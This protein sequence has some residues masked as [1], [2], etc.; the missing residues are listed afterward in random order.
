M[1]VPQLWLVGR[2]CL[3]VSSELGQ[4]WAGWMGLCH[5]APAERGSWS[6]SSPQMSGKG[7]KNEVYFP[8]PKGEGRSDWITRFLQFNLY[9]L[10][11]PT[12]CLKVPENNP[13]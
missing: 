5:T 9:L 10:S 13:A 1:L 12:Q 7:E 11:N 3:A 4:L 2:S 8:D 6:Q